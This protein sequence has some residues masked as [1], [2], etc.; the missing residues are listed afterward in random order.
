MSSEQLQE[1]EEVCRVGPSRNPY[2]QLFLVPRPASLT[3]LSPV[4]RD[5]CLRSLVLSEPPTCSTPLS[6]NL[7]VSFGP[8]TNG[9]SSGDTCDREFVRQILVHQGPHF[10][11]PEIPVPSLVT[12][13]TCFQLDIENLKLLVKEEF[14]S[15]DHLW[16]EVK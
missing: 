8:C 10:S 13:R 6:L 3:E 14:L 9:L 1:K 5:P 4:V 12:T 11:L 16:V 7:C 2:G 15:K